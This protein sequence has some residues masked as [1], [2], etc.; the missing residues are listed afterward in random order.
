LLIGLTGFLAACQ[1]QESAAP[2]TD[3]APAAEPEAAVE[4][5]PEPPAAA[6]EMGPDPTVADADHYT[7]EFEND[8]VRVLRIGY[9][10]GETSVMHYHPDAVAVFLTAQE[11]SFGMPDGTAETVA[12]EAGQAIFTPSGNHLP[13][14]ISGDA[15]EVILVELAEGD[16]EPADA[17]E[18][19]TDPD[20]SVVD[21]DHYTVEF[22]NDQ[23]RV[24]RIAYGPGEE[25]VMHYHPDAIAVFL[26]PQ[27]VRMTMPDGASEE[28]HG[29]AGDVIP[30]PGGQHLPANMAEEPFELILVE[31]KG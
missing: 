21:A 6:P 27:H 29:E 7:V 30:T 13:T 14:N 24:L 5:M 4:A 31:L 26:S 17:A 16:D 18:A 3:A 28:V 20:P 19:E 10:A 25:S 9:Q 15:L 12:A 1:E 22:E 2:E 23:V 11:V 8:Q